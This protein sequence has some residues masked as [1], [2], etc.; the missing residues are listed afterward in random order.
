[1]A[2]TGSLH[3]DFK[4]R[5]VTVLD[6]LDARDR[7][8][9]KQRELSQ[10][11]ENP[12]IS[13]T[14]NVAGPIKNTPLI[15]RGFTE[16]LR[17]LKNQLRA[18][19]IPLLYMEE[20]CEFTGN[21]AL[22]AADTSPETLKKIT[23]EIED[24]DSLGRLFDMD[25][26]RPDGTKVDREEL[27]FPTRTCLICGRPAKD[28]ARNRTHTVSEL[29]EKT[30][31]ILADSIRAIDAE[32]A[33]NLAVRS[34]L[35]E[36]A[37]T[38]K[39]G[40][41]DRANA[42]S[43]KDMDIFT[44]M[45]S[46]SALMPYFRSCALAG[47]DTR[48]LPA[49]ETFKRL[50]V[51]GRRAEGAMYEATN[52]VNTH[53]GAIFS[54]GIMCG[55]LGRLP[56]ELW[57]DPECVLSECAAETAGL[58][59]GYLPHLTEETARTAGEK[60]YVKHGIRGVRGQAEDGFPAVLKHGLPVLEEGLTRGLS[61]ND[62]GC[63]ALLH[64]MVN[65]TDTNMIKRSDLVTYDKVINEVRTLLER[66]PF[67]GK[68]VIAAL[69]EKFIGMNLSPGGTADLLAMTYFLHFLR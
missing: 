46:A 39:P 9:A 58:A 18:A 61:L 60:L 40:L 33:A 16:G 14:M 22:L 54:V 27:G 49:P 55:A 21:E 8:A 4:E 44:F 15:R 7:R 38:P 5:P 10:K 59:E 52:G 35:F 69:D 26:I 29:Q 42:G 51:L 32:T 6:M 25:V 67:P 63:A 17:L 24:A 30:R 11:Y 19:G 34:L 37:T 41:V 1:M 56:R 36:A 66:D 20:I 62:A 48:D 65:E 53:K 50:Q 57:G 47:M 31:E 64:M 28:C 12:L 23:S 3:T 13:F 43:H 68:E 2:N 45:S